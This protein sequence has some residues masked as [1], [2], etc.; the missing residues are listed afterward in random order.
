MI[1]WIY[2]C[3]VDFAHLLDFGDLIYG[4]ML[5][6]RHVYFGDLWLISAATV[7]ESY[8]CM[9]FWILM[10]RR[11]VY[12]LNIYIIGVY[13]RFNKNRALH[14]ASRTMHQKYIGKGWYD[15]IL[16]KGLKVGDVILF[17]V[18]NPPNRM[19]GTIINWDW[20]YDQ[21]WWFKVVCMIVYFQ[22]NI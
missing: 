5:I 2:L 7:D 10:C 16:E 8:I 15:F 22:C 1:L 21:M 14:T 3:Y 6:L 12:F 20:F 19:Y 9:L 17:T 18:N 13:Y 4:C 11:S